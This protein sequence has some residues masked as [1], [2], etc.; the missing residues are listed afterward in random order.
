MK[1]LL[2]KKVRLILFSLVIYSTVYSQGGG[3]T[4]TDKTYDQIN[5]LSTAVPFLRIAPD[6]RSGAMGD[7]GV[8]TEPDA[9]SI[10]WNPAK[11]AFAEKD[12]AFA[13]SYTPWLRELV[14]D[15]YLA[16]LSGYKK[17]DNTQTLGLSLLYWS[18]IHTPAIQI[19]IGPIKIWLSVRIR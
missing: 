10:Y 1:L 4:S 14:S 13:V 2:H 9:N 19:Y 8:A 7:V 11:I 16:Y 15:I 12:M 17:L 5:T 6:G 3:I 18:C